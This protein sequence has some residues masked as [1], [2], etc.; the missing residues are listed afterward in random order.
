MVM[1]RLKDRWWI[2]KAY[3]KVVFTSL[4]YIYKHV[5]TAKTVNIYV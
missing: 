5:Y 1:A 2:V 4:L 3:E